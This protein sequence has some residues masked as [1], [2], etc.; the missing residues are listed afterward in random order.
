[1]IAV[2]VLMLAKNIIPPIR[3]Q[4]IMPMEGF[5]VY[6]GELSMVQ[7]ILAGSAGSLLGTAFWTAI[8]AGLVCALG[9]QYTPVSEWLNSVSTVLLIGRLSLCLS[10]D[11]A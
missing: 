8:L 3:S 6:R 9:S 10:L 2:A 5:L 4:M 11:R 7:V 1:V